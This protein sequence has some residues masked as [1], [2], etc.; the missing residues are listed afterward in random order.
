MLMLQFLSSDHL[1]QADC[2]VRD[3]PEDE[4]HVS[5]L[6]GRGPRNGEDAGAGEVQ[7]VPGSYVRYASSIYESA[8][9]RRLAEGD[10]RVHVFPT[11]RDRDA[12]CLLAGAHP[13]ELMR[14]VAGDR[15]P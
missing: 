14:A 3:W 10:C 11:V 9:P 8:S 5:I 4:K 2:P 12:F 15:L 7:V 13:A 1:I 6:L